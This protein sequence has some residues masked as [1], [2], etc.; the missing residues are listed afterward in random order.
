MT[1]TTILT[2]QKITEIAEHIKAGNFPIVA[3]KLAGVR[4]RTYYHWRKL[5]KVPGNGIYS[6]FYEALRRR[7]LNAKHL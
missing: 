3:C 7:M 6:E 5:G 1:R 4:G 2:E